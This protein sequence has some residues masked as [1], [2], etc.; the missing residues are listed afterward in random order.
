[1]NKRGD[2]LPENVL[3]IIIAVLGILLLLYLLVSLYL[4]FQGKKDIEKAEATV[5][6]ILDF[7]IKLA[8]Q[9]G[10]TEFPVEV[11][12]E[13]NI[14]AYHNNQDIPQC[15]GNCLCIC[16]EPGF[17]GG[18][19]EELCIGKGVCKEV[20]YKLSGAENKINIGDG[21]NI[22]LEYDSSK[23]EYTIKKKQ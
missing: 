20:A 4:T 5:N 16:K 18:T 13:W 8:Q 1:M 17:F 3:K 9:N 12:R 15:S 2:L 6:Y 7:E 19:Q 23:N 22:V 21:V 10:K 14:I 11:P